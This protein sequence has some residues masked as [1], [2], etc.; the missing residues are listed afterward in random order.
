[1]PAA[2]RE[3][4]LRQ[5]IHDVEALE[6]HLEGEQR[7]RSTSPEDP[8]QLRS[9]D[10]EVL[11]S[12]HRL[13]SL[14]RFATFRNRSSIGRLIREGFLTLD[15]VL[16]SAGED[17]MH[18]VATAEDVLA[19]R[20]QCGAERTL[21]QSWLAGD[22]VATV[23]GAPGADVMAGVVQG[24]RSR[25][26]VSLAERGALPS[27]ACTW[28]GVRAAPAL[29]AGELLVDE[30]EFTARVIDPLYPAPDESPEGLAQLWRE[31]WFV[32]EATSS[33]LGV[34]LAFISAQG[35]GNYVFGAD[36]EA[37][38]RDGRLLL[39]LAPVTA[40]TVWET[41]WVLSHGGGAAGRAGGEV[42]GV[43]QTGTHQ[44][45]PPDM[46]ATR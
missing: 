10:L 38:E 14:G 9:S 40:R 35:A 28:A 18:P 41:M 6:R 22:Q 25:Y 13:G 16:D 20:G 19:L 31:P 44:L 43:P 5:P 11:Q 42:L 34:N 37:S 21:M 32:W 15:G 1:M 45:P 29:V 4:R 33:A 27:Q 8:G 30:D 12:V 24:N 7:R 46:P 26:T 23:S 17:F 2:D 36:A 3:A 39:R